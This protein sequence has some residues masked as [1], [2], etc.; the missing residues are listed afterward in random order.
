MLHEPK[1]DIVHRALRIMMCDAK[2]RI[3]D[4][5]VA[6]KTD[7]LDADLLDIEK[8]TA[9]IFFAGWGTD[10]D[11]VDVDDVELAIAGL[12]FVDGLAFN[13]AE[14]LLTVWEVDDQYVVV[15][16]WAPGEQGPTHDC[17]LL[18]TFK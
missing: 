11:N 13:D 1:R 8:R 15:A 3:H 18:D 14:R 5:G 10:I 17:M 16:A 4:K 6:M 12:T 2:T 7:D 9:A